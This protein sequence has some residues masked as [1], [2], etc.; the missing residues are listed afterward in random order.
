MMELSIWKA[1]NITP[2]G[3]WYQS[4]GKGMGDTITTADIKNGYTLSTGEHTWQ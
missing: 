4:V 1:A 3:T 2:T